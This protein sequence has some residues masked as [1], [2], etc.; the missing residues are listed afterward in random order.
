[1]EGLLERLIGNNVNANCGNG[2]GFKGEILGVSD[3][4]LSLKDSDGI[5]F[6]IAVEK[7]ISVCEESETHSRPG[8]VV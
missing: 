1:M 4:I 2:A 7:I 6:Y 3:G 8:F 5:L